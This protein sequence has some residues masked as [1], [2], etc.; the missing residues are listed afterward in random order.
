MSMII[1]VSIPGRTGALL[2]L[3]IRVSVRKEIRNHEL[4]PLAAFA[5][6]TGKPFR[7]QKMAVVFV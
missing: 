5:L 6:V 7:T 4:G 1:R 2:A 3:G